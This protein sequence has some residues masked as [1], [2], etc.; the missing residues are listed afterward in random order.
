MNQMT[1][2]KKKNKRKATVWGQGEARTKN[3]SS[4]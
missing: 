3:K 4:P 2:M 1:H